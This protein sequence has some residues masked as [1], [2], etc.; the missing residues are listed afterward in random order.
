[1][2]VFV[3]SNVK[4]IKPRRMSYDANVALLRQTKIRTKF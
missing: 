1:M 3:P 2:F 4:D